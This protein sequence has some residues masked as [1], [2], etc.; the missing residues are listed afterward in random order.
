MS[1]QDQGRQAFREE[2][3]ELLEELESSLLELEEDPD[4]EE[5]INR[6]FR[7]MHTIKGSGAMFGFD[8]ISKFTHELET[9]FDQVREGKIKVGKDL[10]DLTL[11]A[12]DLILAML[13]GREAESEL[14][15]E[16]IIAGLRMIV[17]SQVKPDGDDKKDLEKVR[18][19]EEIRSYRIMF[20][21]QKEIFLTGS[22][23]AALIE[24]L[25]VLGRCR[26]V[27]HTGDIPGLDD[28]NP[29]LC[30]V[31]WD[32]ILTTDQGL[33]A[34]KDVFIFV[35]D[36]CELKIEQIDVQ[37]VEGRGYKKIGQILV[38][39]GDISPEVVQKFLKLQ[40]PL[41]QLLVEAGLLSPQKVEAAL[42]E[43]EE[44]RQAQILK[45]KSKSAIVSSIRV[46][47][48]KLDYL[49]NLVGELV[50]VQAR[51]S[52]LV[53]SMQDPQLTTL[54]EELERLSDELR[55]STL[56]IR[57]LPIGTIFS[58]FRRLVRDLSRDL[59]KE[60]EL[61]TKGEETEL[62]K[63]VIERL[64]DPLVH[65]LRNSIDH[66]I[67]TPDVRMAKGKPPQGTVV[68]AAEHSGGEVIIRIID[69]GAGID[70]EK[71]RARAIQQ[72]IISADAVLN[73]QEIYDLIFAPGFS[74]AS[75][76]T[77]VS[78]RGVGMDVVKRNIEALRGRIQVESEWGKGTTITLRL[79]LTLAIIDGLQVQVG[80]DFFILPLSVVEECVELKRQHA[81]KRKK[82][83]IINLRG[84]IVPYI[85]LRDCFDIQGRPPE[86]EQVVITR[87]QGSRIGLVVDNVIGEHQTV[88]KSLGRVYR[89]VPGIS[90]ATIKGDGNIALI[91]DVS[92]LMYLETGIERT[93]H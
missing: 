2:A 64:N 44:V 31:W 50:I 1:F 66:G 24:E 22:D 88:I 90:G 21:P 29:E 15:A 70:K 68:L 78:G 26:V 83:K 57:M 23:P 91:L 81:V 63:T 7:A 53:C 4:N 86:I 39:R 51:L 16:E 20:K 52:Q 40:K 74:T 84:E 46:P 65:L 62:D 73:D 14:Q 42:A 82:D 41:G 3:L 85:V 36:D 89:D 27:M 30:Y 10:L 67:E 72:G 80:E 71:V 56:E 8:D 35:E 69:D 61:V 43:Q 45:K 48:K 49:V 92:D 54:A 58:K 18:A 32:V 19:A 25:C 11:K 38:D 33:D 60:I 59:D 37:D 6:V 17:P 87:V 77:N 55:D 28:F 93:T 13:E 9:V 47:A 79:P 34:I 75:Q 76:V 5:L 12:R